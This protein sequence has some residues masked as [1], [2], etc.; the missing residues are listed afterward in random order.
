M[1]VHFSKTV[2]NSLARKSSI[3]NYQYILDSSSVLQTGCLKD[4]GV[5]IE[6][7]LNFLHDIFIYIPQNI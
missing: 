3:L 1:Q 6:Q 2:V 7:K 5:F 4:L